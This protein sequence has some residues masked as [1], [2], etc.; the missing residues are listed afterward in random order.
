M[1]RFSVTMS[2]EDRKRRTRA[3]VRNVTRALWWC[4]RSTAEEE[5]QYA[6]DD[7]EFDLL[8]SDM[9]N[10]HA[11]W[12]HE[13]RKEYWEFMN[14]VHE[15]PRDDYRGLPVDELRR[16]MAELEDWNAT[17]YKFATEIVNGTAKKE[18][19]GKHK[20]KGGL[21][22]D[23]PSVPY[24]ELE[25]TPNLSDTESDS[26]ESVSR[27]TT[28]CASDDETSDDAASI[29]AS[30]GTESLDSESDDENVTV[31]HTVEKT[32]VRGLKRPREMML[33]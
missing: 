27:D 18:S 3:K 16:K 24:W 31:T 17:V 9:L 10:S 20:Y 15:P 2:G 32:E 14:E 1:F 5:R 26:G 22:G 25:V 11:R 12:I 21:L 19:R 33:D 7:E 6:H 30:H 4:I 29:I 8:V 13:K 23:G 28:T